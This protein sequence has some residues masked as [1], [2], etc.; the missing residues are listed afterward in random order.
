[1]IAQYFQ[2]K[3]QEIKFIPKLSYQ[4]VAFLSPTKHLNARSSCDLVTDYTEY[5]YKYS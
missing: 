2:R 5:Y 4:L 1:M 3:T